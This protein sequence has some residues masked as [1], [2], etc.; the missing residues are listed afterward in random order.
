MEDGAEAL[1]AARV[2]SLLASTPPTTTV[3]T[4]F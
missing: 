1:I 4:E 3:A 2:E